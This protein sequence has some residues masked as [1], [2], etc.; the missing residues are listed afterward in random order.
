MKILFII[1]Y[2][3][4]NAPSQRF[5]F[6]QYFKLLEANAINYDVVSFWD[7]STWKIL[8]KPGNS[9]YKLIGF[10]TG[11]IRRIYLLFGLRKYNLLFIHR[12]AFPFGPAIYEWI[13]TRIFRKKYI[14]DF[15][16]AIWMANT[17]EENMVVNSLKGNSKT[18][19][20]CRMAYRISCGNQ[21]LKEY[22]SQFNKQILVNPTTIDTSYHRKMKDHHTDKP[23]IGWTGT[24]TT[25]G[26]L[27]FLVP[28]FKK[29]SQTHEFEL[30]VISNKDPKLDLENFQFI[31]WNRDSEID[32][33]LKF[34][35]G[36]MPMPDNDWTRGKC[37]FK[38]LQYMSLGIP[39][40]AS[41]VG[42]NKDIIEDGVNGFL[43]VEEHDW[44]EKIIQLLD[45]EALRV[46]MGQKAREKVVTNY[47]VSSNSANF[48]N[49]FK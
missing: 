28:I 9:I 43:C 16:D 7:E 11:S 39:S 2:P 14:F 3:L 5:R 25:I 22:A 23:V 19:G 17:S 8:Y 18:D 30:L 45:N 15:D 21:Y 42:V 33:L 35:I 48:L 10:I 31:E 36:L 49:L 38:S 29:I 34:N 40:I 4:D 1:P 47:S 44:E 24:H 13:L 6:E 26:F 41:P 32:D 37:G 12:E 27:D 46:E 20:I